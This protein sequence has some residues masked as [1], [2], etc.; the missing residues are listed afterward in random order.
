MTT[1]PTYLVPGDDNPLRVTNAINK[2]AEQMSAAFT[3][4]D[5]ATDEQAASASSTTTLLTPH[6]GFILAQ[7]LSGGASPALEQ[8]VSDLVVRMARLEEAQAESSNTFLNVGNGWVDPFDNTAGIDTGNSTGYTQTGGYVQ[9]FTSGG[10]VIAGTTTFQGVKSWSGASRLRDGTTNAADT[11]CASIS[12]VNN[13]TVVYAGY[14]FTSSSAIDKIVIYGSNNKGFLNSQNPGVWFQPRGYSSTPTTSTATSTGTMLMGPGGSLNFTDTTNESAGRELTNTFDR[15]TSFAGAG[16]LMQQFG[17]A[18][19][20]FLIAEIEAYSPLTVSNMDLRS[21]SLAAAGTVS[22]MSV[23][24]WIELVDS[25]TIN[26]DYICKVSTDGGT[27]WQ[28]VTLIDA[29]TAPLVSGSSAVNWRTFSCDFTTITGMASYLTPKI[30]LQT[31]NN[32]LVKTH[33]ARVMWK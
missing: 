32:R 30:R 12:S 5:I 17:S 19:D 13:T 23:K 14:M 6:G 22:Q 7:S 29:A 26:T 8:T 21:I 9:P 18:S 3:T 27:N 31:A 28:T 4:A 33:Q 2:N 20:K 24:L 15:S 11:S 1:T 25:I 10:S 16:V